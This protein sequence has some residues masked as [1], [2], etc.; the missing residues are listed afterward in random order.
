MSLEPAANPAP[1]QVETRPLSVGVLVT[2]YDSWELARECIQTHLAL[3]G[4]ELSRVVLLDDAS[5]SPPPFEASGYEM[6]R[7][8]KNLGFAANLNRGVRMF[9]T[10]IV[11]IFDADARPLQ[12]Y[13]D[14]LRRE[15]ASDPRLALVGFATQGAAGQATPSWDKEP[16]AW[17][18]VLGQALYARLQSRIERRE[19]RVCPWLCALAVRRRAFDELGGFDEAFD[20]L[21][22]DLDLAMRVHRSKWHL[23]SHS[24]LL[25]FH[26]GGGTPQLVSGRL[27]RFYANRWRT[28]RKHGKMRSPRGCRAAILVRL[29]VELAVLRLLGRRLFPNPAVRRDKLE[30][31]ERIIA[32]CKR[33][34]N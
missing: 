16:N 12:P 19:T 6:I 29:G 30:G 25:A 11:L 33:H 5:P 23:K 28:L 13:L 21:D 26:E 14:T 7:N 3:H 2:N 8:P 9:E 32:Y 31:R 18:L 22:V 15:F 20:L 4:D 24:G 10:D 34:Y 17:S 1:P 27:L